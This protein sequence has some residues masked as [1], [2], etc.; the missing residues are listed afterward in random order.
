MKW[1][2][3]ILN[4]PTNTAIGLACALFSMLLNTDPKRVGLRNYI[5]IFVLNLFVTGLVIDLFL[6]GSLWWWCGITGLLI[7]WAIDELY[8]NLETTLPELMSGTIKDVAHGIR[9]TIN[10]KLGLKKH[11]EKNEKD[12]S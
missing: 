5:F 3:L 10:L 6:Q 11:D 1:I 4:L 8:L 9:E 7:G 2:D 12:K